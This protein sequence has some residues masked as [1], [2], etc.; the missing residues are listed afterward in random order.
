VVVLYDVDVAFGRKGIP[1]FVLE[2]VLAELQ[3]ATTRHLRELASGMT[4]ELKPTTVKASSSAGKR[5]GVKGRKPKPVTAAKKS[6]KKVAGKT[7]ASAVTAGS[8]PDEEE[9]EAVSVDVFEAHSD[10]EEGE[11]KEEIAKIIKV[12]LTRAISCFMIV[13]ISHSIQRAAISYDAYCAISASYTKKDVLLGLLT[14]RKCAS[15]W[16]QGAYCV[17]GLKLL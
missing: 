12:R 7:A 1:S 11:L 9:G 17:G 10:E 6:K 8:E 3:A 5:S 14:E 13:D 4:L 2:G 15:A 16:F